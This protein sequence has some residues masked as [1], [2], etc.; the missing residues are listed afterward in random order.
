MSDVFIGNGEG[1]EPEI[2]VA[3][4]ASPFGPCVVARS[5]NITKAVGGVLLGGGGL[6]MTGK[7]VKKLSAPPRTR[8]G[9]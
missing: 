5:T 6:W 3:A 4:C 1:H 9:R 8:G 7:I 2:E